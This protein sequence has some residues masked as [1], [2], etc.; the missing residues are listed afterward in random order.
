METLRHAAGFTGLAAVTLLLLAA[1]LR[2]DSS[3]LAAV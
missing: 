3:A 1:Q 2:L